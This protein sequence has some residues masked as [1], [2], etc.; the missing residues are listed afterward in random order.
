M[1]NFKFF[2][3]LIFASIFSNHIFAVEKYQKNNNDI[4][5]KEYVIEKG[6]ADSSLNSI[7]FEKL[8]EPKKSVFTEIKNFMTPSKGVLI[9]LAILIPFVAV[10]LKT[11]WGMPVIWNLLWCCLGVLPGIIHALIVVNR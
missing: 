7:N 6:K 11:D 3:I 2:A 5:N 10:G 4:D 8:I 9:V 1:K